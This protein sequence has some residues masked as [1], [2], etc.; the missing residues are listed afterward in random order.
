L[1]SHCRRNNPSVRQIWRWIGG[2]HSVG[3]IS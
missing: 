1:S 2:Y 3:F